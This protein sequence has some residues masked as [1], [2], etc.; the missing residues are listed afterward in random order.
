MVWETTRF[1]AG[2]LASLL[3]HYTPCG[4][5]P[6]PFSRGKRILPQ[7][8]YTLTIISK[9]SLRLFGHFMQEASFVKSTIF[10]EFYKV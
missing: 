4:V 5:L 2:E 1:P 8:P 3:G 6:S 9:S 7:R 10:T